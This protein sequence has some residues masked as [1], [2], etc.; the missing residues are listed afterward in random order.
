MPFGLIA[1][2]EMLAFKRIMTPP[3]A[4][5]ARTRRTRD[6]LG[7]KNNHSSKNANS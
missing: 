3:T 6:D 5:V 7:F 4:N 1:R 2:S